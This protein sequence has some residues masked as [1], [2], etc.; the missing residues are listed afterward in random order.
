VALPEPEPDGK[1]RLLSSPAF[2]NTVS[3]F[4]VVPLP[5]ILACASRSR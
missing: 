2:Q 5:L 4:F 1:V 3:M